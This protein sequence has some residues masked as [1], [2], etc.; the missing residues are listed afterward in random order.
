M[1]V[2]ATVNGEDFCENRGFDES[3]CRGFSDCCQW[4]SAC[5]SAIGQKTCT[6]AMP[7]TGRPICTTQNVV[8]SGTAGQQS[9]RMGLFEVQPTLTSGGKAVYKNSNGQYL[10]YWPEYMDWRI[11]SDHKKDIAGVISNR[12]I[13][14]TCPQYSG[15][16]EEYVDGS[17]KASSI[18]VVACTYTPCAA[19][20]QLVERGGGGGVNHACLIAHD[21]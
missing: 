18:T 2:G 4:N 14:T 10:Y 17:F 15:G 20:P 7:G 5:H 16:W 9:T 1:C 12:K 13:D 3:T 8:V 19:P 21:L 11:G 6:L